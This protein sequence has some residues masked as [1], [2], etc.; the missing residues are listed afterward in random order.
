MS[1]RESRPLCGAAPPGRRHRGAWWAGAVLFL[2]QGAAVAADC[3][4]SAVGVAFGTY[5]PLAVTHVDATGSVSV[6]CVWTG[7]GGSGRQRVSP[8]ISLN[9]GLPPGTLQQRRLR[10][11]AG[12]L[13]NYN[14]FRNA[15]RTQIWGDG[16]SG[17]YTA[18]T[19][20][21]TLV[22]PPSGHSRTGSRTVYG[23]MPAG[24]THAAPGSYSDTITVTVTF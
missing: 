6:R 18:P 14:L 23:R 24:Q 10:T 4:V 16:S 13:L 2:L 9:A 17:T 22:L 15:A 5:D 3:S 19:V 1:H 7:S 21:A 8:V 11:V 20:P 12:D